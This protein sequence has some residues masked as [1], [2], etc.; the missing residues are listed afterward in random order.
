MAINGLSSYG[1]YGMGYYNYQSSV[2][3]IRLAQA[4]SK[5]PR[6][7]KS[8]VSPVSAVG[9][10]LQS[11]MNFIKKY[12]SNMSELMNTANTLRTGGTSGTNGN[13]KV[14]SYRAD[15]CPQFEGDDP[16]SK[17]AGTGSDE[18]KHW[19]KVIRQSY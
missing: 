3:N 2:N 7:A 1:S 11:S 6:F 13:L 12:S 8:P 10:S 16:E 14:G 5:N 9:G 19:R 4:L 17:P 15:A 18:H